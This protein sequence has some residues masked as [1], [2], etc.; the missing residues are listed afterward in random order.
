MCSNTCLVNGHPGSDDE[1][2]SGG[3]ESI[4]LST[5]IFLKVAALHFTPDNLFGYMEKIDTKI[6]RQAPQLQLIQCLRH[7]TCECHNILAFSSGV[8]LS[9]AGASVESV[10]EAVIG[11]S[12]NATM[13]AW[14]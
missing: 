7:L 14:H 3:A 4:A 1:R 11:N 10:N 2:V 9:S 13:A 6:S 5:F 8:N 12:A